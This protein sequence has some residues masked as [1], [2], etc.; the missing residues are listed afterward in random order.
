MPGHEQ[1]QGADGGA[2]HA[3][4]G[5][6]QLPEL[7]EQPRLREARVA[8]HDQDD[9]REQ[10]VEPVRAEACGASGSAGP[11][12]SPARAARSGRRARRSRSSRSRQQPGHAAGGG[13]QPG[14]RA[15]ARERLR[16]DAERDRDAQAEARG[17]G[18]HVDDDRAAP[19]RQ[20]PAARGPAPRPCA[21]RVS[22]AVMRSRPPA[23][24]RHRSRRGP[25]GR[26]AGTPPSR[27]PGR[28]ARTVQHSYPG[29]AGDPARA[30]LTE[31]ERRGGERV[32]E[33][34]LRPDDGGGGDGGRG[35]AGAR[36]VEVVASLV[37]A[38]GGDR[39]IAWRASTM[40][41][42]PRS[43]GCWTPIRQGAGRV[44]G[45]TRAR[46]RRR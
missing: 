17:R 7:G 23:G 3:L 16:A 6:H 29:S 37:A 24:R 12:R 28:R 31:H 46:L 11:G 38:G 20:A 41:S 13:E 5:E 45:A 8:E 9:V 42:A 4:V 22:V 43:N 27:A 25:R 32:R 2:E 40:P 36:V 34:E 35:G 18:E 39:E 30:V 21:R 44:R 14:Q 19:A 33:P 26:A 15:D 10:Q 1:Q